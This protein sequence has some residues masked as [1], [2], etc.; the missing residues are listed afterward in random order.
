MK[1][2]IKNIF[3]QMRDLNV[4]AKKKQKRE[5]WTTTTTFNELDRKISNIMVNKKQNNHN[6]ADIKESMYMKLKKQARRSSLSIYSVKPS[7]PPNSASGTG[8]LT[9]PV[10]PLS[11]T[12]ASWDSHLWE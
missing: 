11:F 9:F 1:F 10:K 12:V 7:F 6:K 4:K 3:L 2:Y 5:K 8:P